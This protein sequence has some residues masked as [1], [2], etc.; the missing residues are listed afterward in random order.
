MLNSR[1]R[2][3]QDLNGCGAVD[4]GGAI[5]TPLIGSVYSYG[6]QDS[7]GNWDVGWEYSGD[8]YSIAEEGPGPI[9]T[10]GFGGWG[11]CTQQLENAVP[12]AWGSAK[13]IQANASR[14]SA[15]VVSLAR[16]AILSWQGTGM[17]VAA[18][19]EFLFALATVAGPGELVVI[20]TGGGF[21]VWA[22]YRLG[23]CLATNT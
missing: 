22:L 9:Y 20:A 2:L 21:T 23:R 11:N 16:N 15:A 10:V 7:S 1:S 4:T 5:Y 19:A 8:I 14:F 18:A 17:G 12:W 6:N 13:Y 3:T